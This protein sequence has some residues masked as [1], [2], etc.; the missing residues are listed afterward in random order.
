MP[1]IELLV[2]QPTPFCNINCA[3]CYLP[4]RNSKHVIS[5][6]TLINLFSAGYSPGF[7]ARII[8]GGVAPRQT[9]GAP[10]EFYRNAF[11]RS[12]G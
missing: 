4:D 3:Y 12:I 10:P 5:E 1:A 8:S 6:Q 11:R 9:S 7:N 2:I